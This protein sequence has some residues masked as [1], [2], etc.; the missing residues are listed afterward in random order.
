MKLNCAAKLKKFEQHLFF[1]RTSLVVEKPFLSKAY[2][3]EHASF[4]F[5]KV[6]K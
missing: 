4:I 3:L 2:A 6:L 5:L 1:K